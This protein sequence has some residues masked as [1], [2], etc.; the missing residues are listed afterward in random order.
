[1]ADLTSVCLPKIVTFSIAAKVFVA[2]APQFST[3]RVP[4][5]E[6][7]KEFS[8]NAMGVSIDKMNPI[9]IH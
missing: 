4:R 6:T 9:L 2:L 7:L 5:I 3:D 1:M 8:E